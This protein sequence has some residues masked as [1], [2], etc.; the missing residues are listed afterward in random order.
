MADTHFPDE[1]LARSLEGVVTPELLVELREKAPPPARLWDPRG[2]EDRERRPDSRGA[3][4]PLPI[5]GRGPGAARSG[6][7]GTRPRAG[8]ATLP[9]PAAACHR[10]LSRGGDRQPVRPRRGEG[11]RVRDGP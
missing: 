9:Y 5:E 10:F 11:T 6:G 4:H 1:W 8:G 7:Q 3:V 2:P